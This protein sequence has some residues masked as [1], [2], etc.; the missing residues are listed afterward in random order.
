MAKDIAIKVDHVSMK[1]NLSSEKLDS[2]KEYVIK[3]IHGQVKYDEFWALKDISFELEK[4]DRLG[5]LGL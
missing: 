2:I 4:G 5:I 3:L 1:F